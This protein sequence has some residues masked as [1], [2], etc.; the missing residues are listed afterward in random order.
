MR[1]LLTGMAILSALVVPG[2]SRAADG[3]VDMTWDACVGPIDKTTTTAGV[4]GIYISVLGNDVPNKAYDVRI[5]YGNAAQDIPDAWGFDATGCQGSSFVTIDHLA[6][7]AVSKVCPSFM[8]TSSPSL[9]IKDVGLV[10]AGQ[11]YANTLMRCVLA[12][13]YPNGVATVNPATR[14][15][16]A[17]YNFDHTFS[18][19]GPTDP[20][21]TCGGFEEPMCFK[22]Q[23]GSYLDMAGTEFL[24][25]RTSPAMLVSFNG[26]SAC[27]FVPVKPK[28][29]GA[30]KAQYRN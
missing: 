15:F 12:N 29:W 18:V 25:G 10:P 1:K 28:T 2:V 24:F 19:T 3:V 30:I 27:P 21:L 17:R 16:L 6:P 14:Y 13:S 11:P 8:Q 23:Q 7:A 20:G 4:Y 22:F 26:P 5:I 9:Q